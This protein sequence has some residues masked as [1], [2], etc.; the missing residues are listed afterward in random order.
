MASRLS[1]RLAGALA[2]NRHF[3]LESYP[4]PHNSPLPPTPGI[5]LSQS[6]LLFITTAGAYLPASQTPFDAPHA[7]GDYSLRLLPSDTPFTALAYAHEHYDHTAVTADP[8][9]LLPLHHLTNMVADGRIG[10]LA[11]SFISFMGYQPDLT[12]VVDELIPAVLSAAGALDVQAAL[13]V[14]A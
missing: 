7:L 3:R 5:D 1:R 9:V 10:E 2:A 11:P 6:R 13:L 8:Q 4:R 14:P 12:R